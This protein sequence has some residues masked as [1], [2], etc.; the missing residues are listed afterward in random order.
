[1]VR[2][3]YAGRTD[4]NNLTAR[5]FLDERAPRMPPSAGGRHT[6]SGRMGDTPAPSAR[7]VA[8]ILIS[9]V[10]PFPLFGCAEHFPLFRS[11]KKWISVVCFPSFV[12][13]GAP[14]LKVCSVETNHQEA[15]RICLIRTGRR[16]DNGYTL[17]NV[18]LQGGRIGDKQFLL[19]GR[20]RAPGTLDT[21]SLPFG[22]G[23]DIAYYEKKN[24]I[25][26]N[27]WLLDKVPDDT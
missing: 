25:S 3:N 8:G 9:H 18:P 20:V 7:R 12:K 27:I 23:L 10:V 15:H 1:V 5:T 17:L 26:S 14:N 19:R 13:C 24:L 16:E 11:R 2:T 21:S 6:L 4:L 22:W